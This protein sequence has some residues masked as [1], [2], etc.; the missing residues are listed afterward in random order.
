MIVLLSYFHS[1]IGATVFYSFPE[2]P[3]DKDITNRLYDIM[4]QQNE[5][6]FFSLSFENLKILNFYFQIPSEWAR[7]KKEMVMLS[8]IIKQQISPEIEESISILCKKFSE[9]MQSNEDIYTGFYTLEL[10]K[11]DEVDKE[12]II[13]NQNLIKASV[14]DLYWDS[15]DRA[16]IGTER[17]IEN[18][19]RAMEEPTETEDE[20]EDGFEGEYESTRPFPP[21]PPSSP[22]SAAGAIQKVQQVIKLEL[23]CK[24]CG[25]ELPKGQAICHACGKKVV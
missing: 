22:S 1:K 21:I 4:T 15:M 7:G 12:R 11:H 8:I 9:K 25:A 16:Y 2:T 14:Q 19:L 3:L 10:T 13:K 20:D 24:H 5:E 17:V 23:Y 18:R 6:E